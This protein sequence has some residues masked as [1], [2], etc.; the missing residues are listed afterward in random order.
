MASF[1]SLY[2]GVSG[3]NVSQ[4]AL[5][6]T[7]HNLANIDTKGYVR[8]QPVITDFQYVKKGDSHLSSMQLGLG[9]NFAEIKQVRDMFLDQAYRQEIGRQAFYESQYQAISEIE[10][11]FG[12][13]EGVQFQNTMNEFWEA[14]QELS[15][16]PDN[17]VARASFVQTAVSFIERADNIYGQLSDYQINLNT[18]IIDQVNRINE[19][20]NE[21]K[22]LN[23][24]IRHYESAGV[25]KANDLRDQRNLLL[26]ELSKIANITYNEDKDGVVT[27]NLEGMSFVSED[28]V[29]RMET[30]KISE[31]SDMLKPVWVAHGY[32]D[33]FNMDRPPSSMHDT[34]IGSL[35]GLLLARGHKKANY[36]DIPVRERY[37][38][39]SMYQEAVREYNN[40]ISPSVVMTVQA[41]FDQLIHGIV[42]MINDTL[43]P[44]KEVTLADG[45]KMKILDVEKAPVGMDSDR[46]MGEALFTR[47]SMARYSD[48]EEIQIVN[49]DGEI[50]TISARIYIEEDPKDNYSLYT[51][52][53][54]EVNPRV[55]QNKSLLPLMKNDKTGAFDIEVAQEL[56]DK[57]QKPFATLSPNTL[58]SNNVNDYYI[59]FISELA[60]RGDQI[61][62]ISLNQESM[63]ASIDNK[64]AEVI[65]VSSDDELTNLIKYQHSYNAA[66]RYINVVSEMLEHIIMNL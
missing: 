23:I 10:G 19:I 31:D 48:W 9:A 36:T 50:E 64:R 34:D 39:E 41:Q 52:G 21:I 37:E 33:V 55:L 65:G 45:S 28:L 25:E 18:Q 27:V 58:T 63:V 4:A 1:G 62:T 54:I 59:S 26:D 35:K 2:V 12:E 60:N 7:S 14:M 47:K 49:E 15:R 53:E 29:Y 22:E 51:I 66:A 56:L 3:L 8:Q 42:T 43:S 17:I 40:K 11:L 46:E 6:V 61:N 13:L 32:V 24:K 30:V 5:N 44:N 57:W 20:G 16:E 38:T